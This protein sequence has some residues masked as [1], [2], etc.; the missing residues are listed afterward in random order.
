[1]H[2]TQD[3]NWLPLTETPI[4]AAA[5]GATVSYPTAWRGASAGEFLTIRRGRTYLANRPDFLEWA[6]GRKATK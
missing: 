5:A 6:K 1:M 4:V 3:D 2:A